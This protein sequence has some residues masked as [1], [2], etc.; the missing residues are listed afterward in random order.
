MMNKRILLLFLLWLLQSVPAFAAN[1]NQKRNRGESFYHC[2]NSNTPGVGNFWVSLNVVGHV[3]DDSPIDM[4]EASEFQD[5][6]SSARRWVS[7]IRAFPEMYLQG[8]ILDF[9]S[10]HAYSRP[11]SYGFKPGWF[12]GGIKCTWPN[13]QDIRLHGLGLAIDY[14]YQLRETT[15]TLGGYIGFMPEGFVVKGHNLEIQA[16]H[17]LD[18]IPLNSYLPIRVLTNAGVRLPLSKRQE[19][20]QLLATICAVYSGYGFDFYAQYS[21]ESF[22]NIFEPKEVKQPGK[23]FLLWFSENP[24]YVTLGGDIRYNNGITLSLAVP[25]L[26][27]VNQGSHMRPEDI[28]ELITRAD[29]GIYTYE[30]EHGIVDPFDPWYVKWKICGSITFPIRFE[31]TSTEMRRNFLILK[32]RKKGRKIDI[33]TRIRSQDEKESDEKN[34]KEDEKHRLEEIKKKREQLLK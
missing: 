22:W 27:S 20:F 6:G 12:G 21:I 13:N 9:L 5:A 10:A 32:N 29:N 2:M 19:L 34:K 7:N 23:T 18:L 26:L 8:G 11:L 30:K 33:D 1:Q 16:L 3:W 17:E 4:D 24:M 14:K 15:P 25:I 31:M 28:K